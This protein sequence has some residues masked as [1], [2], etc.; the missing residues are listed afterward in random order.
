M[1][2]LRVFPRRTKATP[3]DEDVRFGFPSLFDQADKVLISVAFTWD[4]P[5]ADELY[6]EW[7]HVAQAEI[8]GPALGQP[9]GQ[10]E[11]GKFLKQ[12]YT[13]TSRGC[14]NRCWF[15]SVW[16]REPGV[17]ELEV[18][19]GWNVL[20]DNLLAT[21]KDHQERVFQMLEKH[22]GKIEF[23]GG[24][25]AK[26]LTRSTAERIASLRPKQMF[27]AYDTPD[28]L[29]PLVEAS[30]ILKDAGIR[31]HVARCYVLIGYKG[32]TMEKAIKRLEQ[33]MDLG[34]MPMAMLM[35]D[36]KG[37]SPLEWRRFQR[38]WASPIILGAKF[39]E[40]KK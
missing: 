24:L 2:I 8:G 30:K 40:A 19:D 7:K 35:R 27:F 33:T 37:N 31:H 17:L 10:F 25:E 34:Y 11:A 15:C 13:I 36:E 6:G 9:S 21:S 23:T 28:D 20:D 39:R 3:D 5:K 22:K 26:L 14:P 38:E 29:D 18:K 16:R 12:G 1:R 32:D 4:I